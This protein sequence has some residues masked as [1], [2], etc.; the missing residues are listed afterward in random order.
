MYRLFGTLVDSKIFE[1]ENKIIRRPGVEVENA[2]NAL[3]K[4][5]T[6]DIV[7]DQYGRPSKSYFNDVCN[8]SINPI[9][10]KL[11]QCNPDFK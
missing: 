7:I 4:G 1:E 2:I 9:T 11:V 10:G 6:R 5:D 3:L 8:V